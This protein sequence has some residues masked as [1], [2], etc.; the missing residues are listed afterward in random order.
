[1]EAA[2]SLDIEERRTLI[3]ETPL[4]RNLNE[5][6]IDLIARYS[7]LRTFPQGT[8]IFRQGYRASGIYVIREGDVSITKE[9]D[10]G[11]SAVARFIRGES[12]LSLIH[13]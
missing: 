12:F 5:D 3:R 7:E 4:F 8:V 9:E 13:I 11:A 10:G 2:V 6:A 1:M